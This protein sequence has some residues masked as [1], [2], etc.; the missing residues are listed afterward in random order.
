MEV[1]GVGSSR[2]TD[3]KDQINMDRIGVGRAHSSLDTWIFGSYRR[4]LGWINW[5]KMDKH[6][7]FWNFVFGFT[8]LWV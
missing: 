2:I 7:T 4:I 6:T 3:C 8:D 5:I 1:C